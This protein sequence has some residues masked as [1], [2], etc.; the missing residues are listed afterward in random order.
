MK[1]IE[2]L[3]AEDCQ[4]FLN[5]LFEDVDTKFEKFTTL[6]SES[7]EMGIDYSI[8]SMDMN[9]CHISISNPDLLIWLYHNEIDMT[10]PLKQLKYEYNDMDETNSILFEY[11]IEIGRIIQKEHYST[12]K[13]ENL[14]MI[15]ESIEKIQKDLVNKI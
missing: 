3:T 11:A 12:D 14:N 7:N 10:I 1:K 5:E 6:P 9:K 8:K 13:R 4:S 2:E 15:M